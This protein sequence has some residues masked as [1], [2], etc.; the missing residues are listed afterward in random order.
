MLSIL[1]QVFAL[2]TLPASDYG[3]FALSY[4]VLGLGTSIVFAFICE[5][6]MRSNPS[7]SDWEEYSHVLLVLSSLSLLPAL[8]LGALGGYLFTGAIYGFAISASLYRTGARYFQ[9]AYGA[10]GRVGR[11][12]LLSVIVFLGTS[13]VTAP[14][15]DN[16]FSL[17]ISWACASLTAALF[18][19]APSFLHGRLAAVIW[20]KNRWS[21]IKFLAMDSALIEAGSTLVPLA[22][23]P[24]M[25]L[26]SF[27][28]YRSVTSSAVPVRLI[29]N[30]LRPQ[31]ALIPTP[32]VLSSLFISLAT[33]AGI[34]LGACVG[35]VLAYVSKSSSLSDSA[36]SALSAFALPVGLYVCCNFLSTLYYLCLRMKVS[37]K[38][39]LHYRAFQLAT[40]ILAPF[41]GFLVF[42]LAGAVWGYCIMSLLT[43]L[44]SLVILRVKGK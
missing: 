13:F 25:G 30:P 34:V 8:L 42:G 4:L 10:P 17:G 22:L 15:S 33:V 26:T 32:R 5:A 43:F 21:E 39:L 7:K 20:V 19:G 27:G 18:S 6:W 44:L 12:D 38:H 24:F 23:T 36:V 3:R 29:L 37:G 2:T 35:G 9:V 40:S 1:V 16:L 41:G 14:V 11:A 28:I 31:L